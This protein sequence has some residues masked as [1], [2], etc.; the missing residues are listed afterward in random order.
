MLSYRNFFSNLG[1]DF[2]KDLKSIKLIFEKNPELTTKLENS[3][4]YYHSPNKT[5]T[6]FYLIALP[7]LESDLKDIKKHLWNKNDADLFF[8]PLPNSED[9][10]MS[11]A[12]YSPLVSLK[13][14]I[15]D[16]FNTLDSDLKKIEKIKYWQFDSG[17]FWLNYH[18]FIDKAKY[19]GIDKDLASTLKVLRDQLNK[20]LLPLI[21]EEVKRNSVVQALI[22]RTLY[23]KYL[24]DN[25]IINSD[26]YKFYFKNESLD[27]KQLLI[28][29]NTQ[30]INRLFKEIHKIF[31][32]N[33]FE[34]PTIENDYLT[35]EVCGLIVH[36]FNSDITGQLRLFDFE[37]NIL[38]VEFISYIYE[39]FLSEKQKD[40]GIYYTPKKLAQLIVDDTII[41]NELGSVL[42][43][44][45]GSGMFLIVAFQR[46]LEI[47]QNK[48]IEPKDSLQ[49]IKF[50][51]EILS[52]Y[53]FG[54]E[55]E[56][57]AQRFTLF[58]LS[59]QIFRGIEP[60]EIKEYIAKNIE[61]NNKIDLFSEFSFFENIKCTNTLHIKEDE[62]PFK[63][64]IFRYIVGN[65]PF[66]E[67]ADTEEL[68]AEISFLG[69]YKV[70]LDTENI[71][72]AN[73]I[74]GKSQ[75]SQCFL[76]KIKDWGDINTRFGFVSNSSNFYND[77]SVDFQR[78]F[79]SSFNIEKIYELSRVKNILFEKAQ[80]SVVS[81]IF[82]LDKPLNNIVAYYP[83][84]LGLFSEKPFEL[85]IIQ[86]D[87]SIQ[88]KQNE[89]K[90]QAIR[91]RD[92]LVGNEYDFSLYHSLNKDKYLK[93]YIA[94][95]NNDR[96]LIYE[97]LK[98]VGEK[99][100]KQEFGVDKEKWRSLDRENQLEYFNKFREKYTSNIPNERC[101]IELIKPSN[102]TPFGYKD[103]CIYLEENISNLERGRK[104]EIYVGEKN[105]FNRTGNLLLPKPLVH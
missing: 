77:F 9:I 31:N 60:K 12:K 86:E 47:A 28:G 44:S 55:K 56:P 104:P 10:A 1:F 66:F 30:Q 91:L 74:V 49:K 27:Y 35:N 16:T 76:L 48:G 17:A 41:N 100:I 82:T 96:F 7:L 37:F 38:P 97:G 13:D 105:I 103:V 70:E 90:N 98:V 54:I 59:L 50:R 78:Y 63:N 51:T 65:P 93:D 34:H 72:K 62:I 94:Q 42:D 43:P 22:D 53:I 4:F 20:T 15:L 102:L 25:H 75:I 18:S 8:Y 81:I 89:L 67:I 85:L 71:V 23:I 40:N 57:T 24:E 36:S 68:C 6:S 5:N 11:Y 2:E 45:C 32:N 19:K 84:D 80:E 79:Y 92:F 26:F 73:T 95:D 58:S 29:G 101:K 64:K 99:A 21:K 46:L 87:K 88:I 52:K 3:T 39:V 69:N 83:V 61:E 14:S 33:L